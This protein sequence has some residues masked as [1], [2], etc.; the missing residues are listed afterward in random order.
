MDTRKETPAHTHSLNPEHILQIGMGF[1]AS[2]TV[3]AA[4]NFRLFTL[5]AQKPH[6]AQEIRKKLDLHERAHH[7]FL[8]ALVALG[9]LQRTGLNGD[10]FYQNTPETDFFLDKNKPSYLGGMLE[11]CNNRLYKFWNDLEEGLKTGL[12]QNELKQNGHTN[13]FES[14]YQNPESL[15]EFLQA[16]SGVQMGAFISF[17]K[18]F[19]FSK[20]STFCDAGGGNG[21]LCIQVA[22]NQPHMQC[23]SFDLP[24]VKEIAKATIDKAA[25][26]SKVKTAS[27]DF[28]TGRLPN[29]DVIAMGNVLH[30]WNEKEKLQLVK[31]AFDALPED[32][33]FVCIENIIDNDRSKNAF[34]LLMSLNMLIDTKS[35]FDF[36]FNDFDRWAH[37]T[38]F[39]K[40]E[41]MPLAGPTSAAIAYK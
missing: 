27:G 24:A 6:S 29:S 3:L 37:Q 25:L 11:M 9:F 19:N 35:G 10:A 26:S 13:L 1:W 23:T 7:D 12:P 41:W 38:G 14:L 32:G 8:D 40:T 4:V 33:A 39:K 36:T 22:L 20:Y 34:G 31:H 2:K 5:L 18:Q 15:T 21:A 28:F 30:D 17:A 16:M